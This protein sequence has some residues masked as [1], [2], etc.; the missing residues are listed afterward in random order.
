MGAPLLL[1]WAFPLPE[2][3]RIGF[4]LYS[5][6]ALPPATALAFIGGAREG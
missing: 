4:T 2:I 3:V 1:A 5:A 6:L